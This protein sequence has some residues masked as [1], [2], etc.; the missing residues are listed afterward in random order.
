M[1]DVRE[2]N[3]VLE[4]ALSTSK[5]GIFYASEGIECAEA[6]AC[7][8]NDASFGNEEVEV[9]PGVYEDNRSQQGV[10]ICLAPADAVNAT[11]TTVH[12]ISWSSMV[13]K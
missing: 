12:P 1:K 8:I 11:V 9:T 10:F 4:Y 3:Q 5:E 7:S 13:I 2:C 6:V